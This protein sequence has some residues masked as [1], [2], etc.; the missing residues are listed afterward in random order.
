MPR[1]NRAVSSRRR[2]RVA[3]VERASSSWAGVAKDQTS[4]TER[5]TMAGAKLKKVAATTGPMASPIGAALPPK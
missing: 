1:R 5:A 4:G 3:P 2:A